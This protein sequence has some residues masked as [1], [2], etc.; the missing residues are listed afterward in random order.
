M[1]MVTTLGW[2]S[3]IHSRSIWE[4]TR[5]LYEHPFTVNIAVREI[6]TNIARMHRSVKDFVLSENED[7]MNNYLNRV[8]SYEA[9]VYKNF[10]IV[11][12]RYLGRK[13]TIDSAYSSFQEWKLVRDTTINLRQQGKLNEA[14]FR[15]THQAESYVEKSLLPSVSKL[16]VFAMNKASDFYSKAEY[17]KNHLQKEL[18]IVI[19]IILVIAFITFTAIMKGINSPIK[20]LINSTLSYQKGDYSA[21]SKN[22][23]E[24]EI[25]MLARSVNMMAEN[26]QSDMNIKTNISEIAESIIGKEELMQFSE[27]LLGILVVK[28][29]SN[30]GAIYFL[31]ETNSMFEPYFSIGLT[32][33]KKRS[34]SSNS[35]EGEFGRA[36]HSKKITRISDIPADTAFDFATVAGNFKPKEIINIPILLREKPIAIISL[37]S[38]HSYSDETLEVIRLSE[39]NIA[40][41]INSILNFEKIREISHNMNIQNIELEAQSRE[42]KL[43]TDELLEQNSE[44]DM[45]KSQIAEANRLKSEFL[46]SMSHELR[47]PLNSVIALTNVLNR[48][49]KNQIPDEEYSYIGVIERNGKNLLV[50][51]NDILDLSR[52][53]AGKADIQ[54]SKFS[55]KELVDTILLTIQ[56]QVIEKE[57]Q[58][59]NMVGTDIPMITSDMS[60]CH[61]ILQNIIGNAVKFTDN[62]SVEITSEV[63]NDEVHIS[64]KDTGIGI[65]ED[66]IKYIFE[67]FRQVDGTSSRKHEGTGLGLAIAEKYSRLING[68]I[69]VTSRVNEGSTFTFILPIEPGEEMKNS[70]ESASNA[71]PQNHYD[72]P[73]HSDLNAE[74]KSI[75]I[76]EDSEPAIIQLTEILKE[77][78]YMLNIA[79]SGTE[80]LKI[81][82]LNKPDGIILDLMMPGMDGFEVLEKIRADK[83]ISKIPVLILTAKYLSNNELRRLTENNIHQLIQKGDITRSDL[84]SS[85]RRMH[86]K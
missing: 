32:D 31:N 65:P 29:N 14:A 59:I 3:Y 55:V 20:E 34:F 16:K 71:T 45:Q 53:E 61:H 56:P 40:T 42:L 8:K 82:K 41:G 28:T 84:L 21:R 30:I 50:L 69:N 85:I 11:Y 51:I 80:A 36:L 81:V 70:R 73:E 17:T 58:T 12:S 76:I 13:S 54:F 7:E 57:I 52:I 79:R 9:D 49:L 44:L 39:K 67:E 33:S 19:A 46:S 35:L 10:E 63:I 68:R 22:E 75:L 48:R 26:I 24:N 86:V 25:G 62:G 23:S 74:G 38:L 27:S 66:Q 60:K 2:L 78:G 64:V 18:L 47:T 72:F 83:K 77:Q 43:Q 4:N 37:A 15:T 5:D 1:V 6:E